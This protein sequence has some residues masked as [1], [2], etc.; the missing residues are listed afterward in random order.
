ML[1]DALVDFA[2]TSI[3]ASADVSMDAALGL[4]RVARRCTRKATG[5][6]KRSLSMGDMHRPLVGAIHQRL[7]SRTQLLEPREPLPDLGADLVEQIVDFLPLSCSRA[8]NR[9]RM[10]AAHAKVNSVLTYQREKLL[11]MRHQ[12]DHEL[13]R[14]VALGLVWAL[15]TCSFAMAIKSSP[16]ILKYWLKKAQ[17]SPCNSAATVLAPRVVAHLALHTLLIPAALV[18]SGGCCVSSLIGF[19][20]MN[21]T[22]RQALVHLK[23]ATLPARL[24]GGLVDQGPYALWMAAVHTLIASIFG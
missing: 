3:E 16:V 4:E 13:H 22:C 23:L 18:I 17:L 24:Q 10:Q 5:V 19:R 8:L 11:E 15:P 6:V 1:F 7:R 2:A 9:R 12:T 21:A 20:L 14:A